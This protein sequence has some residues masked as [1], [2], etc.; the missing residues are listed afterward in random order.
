MLDKEV[1][2]NIVSSLMMGDSNIQE[3]EHQGYKLNPDRKVVDLIIEGLKN[4]DRHCPC[5]VQ[6]TPENICS[7]E[8]FINTGKC[9]CKLWVEV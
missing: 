3:F 1:F 9:C 4:K 6:K 2:N 8:E 7:C 5:R